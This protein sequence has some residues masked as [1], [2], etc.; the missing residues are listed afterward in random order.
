MV[1]YLSK[2]VDTGSEE[3]EFVVDEDFKKD[4]TKTQVL[5]NTANVV[6]QA[7]QNMLP[8]LY[9]PV[10]ESTGLGIEQ[11]GY[12]TLARSLLQSV[13]SP[14]WGWLADKFSR[15]I[16]LSIGCF[17]WGVFTIVVGALSSFWGM[18]FVRAFIGLGLAV[19]FPTA[20]SLIAD[21]FPKAKR[22]R[23]FGLLGLT[24][25]I[26]AIVGTLFATFL[27]SIK[28]LFGYDWF[29]GWRLAFFIMGALSLILGIF[30][31]IFSKDPV[32][33]SSDSEKGEIAQDLSVSKRK[34]TWSDYKTILTNK[35]FILIVLQGCAGS[36]PWNSILWLTYWLEH[37]GFA[38]VLAGIAFAVIAIGAALGNLFG[39]YFGD[40][41]AKRWP[42]KGRIMVAQIS[43]ILGIPM[44]FLIFLAIP[45]EAT[46]AVL[47]AFI[48]L[49]II[50]GFAISWCAPAANNP[51]FSELFDPEIRSSAFSIDRLFEGSI[52]AS[53]TAIV[54]GIATL[55]GFINPPGG[56]IENLSAAQIATNVDAMAWG[57][58]IATTIPWTLCAIIYSFIY[59]TYPKDRDN[60]LKLTQKY[61][62]LQQEKLEKKSDEDQVLIE[63][64]DKTTVDESEDDQEIIHDS[65]GG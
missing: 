65:D 36:I 43:V 9:K 49:G 59:L 52:A 5:I 25:I 18:F 57:V 47:I 46:T 11:L 3:E 45:R 51:I 19:I 54:A 61:Q 32:R 2:D 8:M 39:G 28:D 41:A 14:I 37:I 27:G 1:N 58:I 55:F 4:R 16:V 48:A 42:N 29:D 50:T 60:A 20:Q 10:Q 62:P 21:Y 30:I 64:I 44:M 56:L 26:G 35:T 22:G 24:G 63:E 23:A 12:I 17:I 7:D 15:K 33:G 13:S 38:D 53:G 34:F 6:D 40:W 31:W